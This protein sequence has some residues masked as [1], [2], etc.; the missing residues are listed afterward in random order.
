M[1]YWFQ[2]WAAIWGKEEDRGGSV[3]EDAVGLLAF[4]GVGSKVVEG[5]VWAAR[6]GVEVVFGVEL[7]TEPIAE[8][9]FLAISSVCTV[10]RVKERVEL[11][12]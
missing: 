9:G 7:R 1:R 4:E 6:E 5:C 2:T 11:G 8:A 10:A 12:L 3:D